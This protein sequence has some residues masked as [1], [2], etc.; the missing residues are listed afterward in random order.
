MSDTSCTHTHELHAYVPVIEVT[1]EKT[2][3]R[4][5]QTGSSRI[6]VFNSASTQ[7]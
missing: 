7:S 5:E 3:Q 4:V 2:L 1:S 6:V